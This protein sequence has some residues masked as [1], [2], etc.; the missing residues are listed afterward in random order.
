MVTGVS[1]QTE[2]RTKRTFST[3][4]QLCFG[5]PE[6]RSSCSW[7]AAAICE[8]REQSYRKVIAIFRASATTLKLGLKTVQAI[9]AGGNGRLIGS[10][11]VSRGRKQ[12]KLI[13]FHAAVSRLCSPELRRVMNAD[14]TVQVRCVPSACARSS[15]GRTQVLSPKFKDRSVS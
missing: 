5:L 2:R 15:K 3:A 4:T 7:L 14:K 1:W 12:R 10:R 8:G 6:N 13:V 9:K 11:Q